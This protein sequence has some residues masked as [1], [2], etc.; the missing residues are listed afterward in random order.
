MVKRIPLILAIVV[1]I[2]AAL[3]ILKR[4]MT[5]EEAK[6]ARQCQSLAELISAPAD[7]KLTSIVLRTERLKK[8]LADR[9]RFEVQTY[10]MTE[11]F[12]K[13]EV[14]SRY[15]AVRQM[16]KSADVLIKDID[17]LDIN[18]DEAT[19]T[20]TVR[21]SA[22]LDGGSRDTKTA[23]VIATLNRIDGQWLFTEFVEETVLEK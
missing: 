5:T 8:V 17:V 4:F 15:V 18:G 14:V 20:F 23:A 6:I 7:E 11:E 9:C 2:V 1:A 12:S 19:A 16:V 13:E 22:A 10:R 3:F 21:A